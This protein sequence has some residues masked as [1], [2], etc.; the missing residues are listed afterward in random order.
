MGEIK[1]QHSE[2]QDRQNVRKKKVN[3]KVMD[4]ID[5]CAEAALVVVR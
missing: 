4:L 2:L 5:K 1:K 3:R